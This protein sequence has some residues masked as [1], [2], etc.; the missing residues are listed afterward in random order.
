MNARSGVCFPAATLLFALTLSSISPAR[1]EGRAVQTTADVYALWD[2]TNP[3]GTATLIRNASGIT[4]IVHTSGLPAGQAVT[5]WFVVINHPENCSATPCALPADVF[6]P[7]TGGDFHFGS[8]HVV[9]ANGTATFAGRLNVGELSGSGRAELGIDDGVPL[10][11]PFEAEVVLALH[12]HGPALRGAALR[13]QLSSFSGGCEV[14]L[15]PDGFAAGPADVPDMAGECSTIQFSRHTSAFDG[16][17]PSGDCSGGSATPQ[18][19]GSSAALEGL[20]MQL[21]DLTE[22]VSRISDLQR[23]IARALSINP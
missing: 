1:A 17:C 5:L 19:G 10:S 21:R 4:A 23:R 14:F 12:S 16:G 2:D 13:S 11:Q 6:A 15:G 9:G 8:G 20:Q 22:S 3:V 18:P 7:T